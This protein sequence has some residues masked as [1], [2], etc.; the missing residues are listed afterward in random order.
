MITGSEIR[1][2]RAKT[3]HA[4]PILSYTLRIVRNVRKW[5]KSLFEHFIEHRRSHLPLFLSRIAFRSKVDKMDPKWTKM[6]PRLKESI[7]CKKT[8]NFKENGSNILEI[9]R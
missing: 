3:V 1:E 8:A 2:Q 6:S 9:Q 5:G 7:S 4:N